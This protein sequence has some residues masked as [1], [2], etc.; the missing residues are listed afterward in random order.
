[1]KTVEGRLHC[2]AVER[3]REHDIIYVCK[4]ERYVPMRVK[5]KRLYRNFAEMLS[6]Y[7][8]QLKRVLPLCK[9]IHDAINYYNALY[10]PKKIAT[11]S[12]AALELEV[13]TN[14]YAITY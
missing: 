8:E 14:T 4:H 11:Y 6:Q 5:N 7:C 9:D 2:G 10:A 1:M 3:V 12:V 13:L